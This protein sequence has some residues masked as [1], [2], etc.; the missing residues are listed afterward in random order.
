MPETTR[1]DLAHR[2]DA[3]LDDDVAAAPHGGAEAAVVP[4]PGADPVGVLLSLASE[5]RDVLHRPVLTD[6]DRM[7]IHGR[8]LDLLEARGHGGLRLHWPQ[9][10]HRAVHP[11]VLGG[12][13]AAVL[14][15][16]GVA[17]LQ[18][19]GHGSAAA[20]QAA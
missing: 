4:L 15:V 16:V 12:A 6:A 14:A 13:A 5:I 3:L 9:L 2:L 8:T 11:A 20:I 1:I 19:R 18:R 17:A 10:G 7:R